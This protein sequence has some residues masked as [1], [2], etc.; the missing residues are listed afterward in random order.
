MSKSKAEVSNSRDALYRKMERKK[1]YMVIYKVTLYSSNLYETRRFYTNDL[2]FE[3]VE[4]RETSF[5][6]K[7]GKSELEFREFKGEGVPFYHYAFNIPANQFQEYKA[8]AKNSVTLNEEDGKDEVYFSFSNADAC[9][10]TDPSG[11]IVEL[12]ARY[13]VAKHSNEIPSAGGI[14]NISEINLTTQDIFSN[15]R[16]LIDQGIPVR[17]NAALTLEGLNFMGEEEEGA[18][19]LLGT[20]NRRW[21]FSDKLSQIYPLAIEVNDNL[22]IELDESGIVKIS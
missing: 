8:W 21:F 13:D 3:L 9:Y 18:F 2:G 14:L 19:L 17:R 6:V 15:G 5:T 1:C 16:K 7:V 4:S 10:F 11:N 20:V 12:I 22:R